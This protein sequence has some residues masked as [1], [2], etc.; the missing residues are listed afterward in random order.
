MSDVLI[1][2]EWDPDV[3]HQRVTELEAAGYIARRESY[4]ITAEMDPETG[5]IV[6]LHTVE[7]D[8]PST[9]NQEG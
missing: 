1:V 5:N 6:H 2:R 4:A 9:N 3:F 7:M 8:L